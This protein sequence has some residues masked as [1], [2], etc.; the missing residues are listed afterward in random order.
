[1]IFNATECT[2]PLPTTI[3]LRCMGVS[4]GFCLGGQA[5]SFPIF[6]TLVSLRINLNDCVLKKLNKL[7]LSYAQL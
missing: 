3:M 1:M 2:P 7:G 5:I 6:Q 4:G